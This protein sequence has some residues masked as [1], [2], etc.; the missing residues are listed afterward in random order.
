MFSLSFE[1]NYGIIDIFRL[2]GAAAGSYCPSKTH[3]EFDVIY[4]DY[5]GVLIINQL[6]GNIAKLK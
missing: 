1:Y 2:L 5:I 6:L 3:S 4:V